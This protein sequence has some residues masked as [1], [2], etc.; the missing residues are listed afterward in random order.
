MGDSYPQARLA[1]V[2]AAPV[3][4]DREATVAKACRLID[5][6]ADNGAKII[7]FPE[8]FIP[9]FPDWYHWFMPR[10]AEAIGF[11]KALFKNAVE[12]P[13]PAVDAIAA[14]ARR[15]RT[16]VVIGVNERDK[17]TM[18]TLYNS[19]LFFGPDGA[20]LGVHRKLM[21][22]FTERLVHS[23]GDG[24]S[25]RT[26]PTPFGAIGGLI[27]GENTN[28]LARFALLAQHE[29][30]HV[31]SW[32]AFVLGKRNF[33]AIDIR[34]KYH[35]FEGRVFV[36]SAC[37]VL[38]DSCLDAMGLSESQ[39]QA[40]ACRGGHSGILGPDGSYIAG[41]VGDTE[42]TVY[43]EADLDKVIEGKLSHDLT[44][45]YNR[46]DVFTLQVR[47]SPRE[48]LR[49]SGIE[50]EATGVTMPDATS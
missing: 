36:I 40:M 30:I 27:C 33:D 15:T 6:A 34:V 38:D 26:Y 8:G 19:Q 14:A 37:G 48:A 35:A 29:R 13:G 2:Q 16:H 46:F 41:P 7:G 10:S 20:L 39:R 5:E 21:P 9:G 22:T 43:A 25:M 44:G 18:G 28:S 4:L 42:Q 1:A 50:T 32:P 11:N 31:A 23:S 24:S 45:H 49:L 3:W 12:I 47:T 17:G